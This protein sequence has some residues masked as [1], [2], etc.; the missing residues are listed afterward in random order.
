MAHASCAKIEGHMPN[1]SENGSE[2]LSNAL[3]L[4][5]DA[6]QDDDPRR[7]AA[8]H[9]YDILD[10]LPFD[11]FD[12]ITEMAADIFDAPI[13]AV[14][15]ADTDRVWCKPPSIIG[16]DASAQ[17]PNFSGFTRSA[18]EG[19][20]LNGKKSAR[21]LTMPLV[22]VELGL[23]FYVSAPL[24]TREGYAVGTLC[25]IDREPR[26]IDDHQ[27]RHLKSLAAIV[28]DQ[29]EARL[30]AIRAIAQTD[31]LSSETDHRVMNSL[32]F[33]SGLLTMQS[34]IARTTEAAAQLS[35][36]ANRVSAVARVHRHFSLNEDA[37]R[38][39]VLA[40][41]Q[42]LCGELAN[43]LDVPIEVTGMEASVPSQ[44]IMAI[45]FSVN[46]FVSNAKKYG[47]PPIR[48]TFE[49]DEAGQHRISVADEGSG[50]PEGFA[51][52]QHHRSDGLGMRV[53]AALSTQLSGTLSA[54]AN[55]TGRGAYFA[56]TFPPA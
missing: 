23:R 11:S 53:V 20:R 55:A 15:V 14:R 40:Y 2:R 8:I 35:L 1:L 44:Q 38:V 52:D 42:R 24:T 47:A 56:V 27:V 4:V 29:M 25:V 41:L 54:G 30:S 33:V 46:E 19:W 34:R 3:R 36:A 50:L 37:Q 17:S 48:V 43:I 6:G 49:S 26:R 32:Q 39:P 5:Q 22:A 12:H 21:S 51:P 45:G 18:I 13:A 16:G 9:A 7:L 10:G 28:M 31:I